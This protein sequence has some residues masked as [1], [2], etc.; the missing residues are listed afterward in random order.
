MGLKLMP[1][2]F[3]GVDWAKRGTAVATNTP[4]TRE[5]NA[6]FISHLQKVH[7]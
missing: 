5:T 7:R 6:F 2:K 4:K 3:I 1:M